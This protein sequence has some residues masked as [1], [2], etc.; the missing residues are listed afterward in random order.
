MALG[1]YEYCYLLWIKNKYEV[2]FSETAMLGRQWFYGVNEKINKISGSKRLTQ[3]DGYSETMFRSL[4]AND[5]RSYDISDYEGATDLVDFSQPISGEHQKRFSFVL[6]GG[7]LEHV[8]DFTTSVRNAMNMPKIGGTICLMTP[9]NSWNGHGFYQFS[10]ELFYRLFCEENGYELLDVSYRLCGDDA[11]EGLGTKLFHIPDSK[12][13]KCKTGLNSQFTGLLYVTARRIGELPDKFHIYESDYSEA[14][15]DR[16]IDIDLKYK[17]VA[18]PSYNKFYDL[19]MEME[20]LIS[21]IKTN[22]LRYFFS[23]YD[24]KIRAIVY[25]RGASYERE[26]DRLIENENIEIELIVDIKAKEIK[27]I[28]EDGF[29]Y[30]RPNCI[31]E[32]PFDI[33]IV[34]SEP[35]YYDIE[36]MLIYSYGLSFKQIMSLQEVLYYLS[37]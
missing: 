17:V 33:I 18:N 13:T 29:I 15:M 8:F 5:I 4:G 23:I 24:R 27:T 12:E 11:I 37:R 10:A 32:Y 7:L 20:N 22:W 35:H 6:D 14:W 1:N 31:K 21:P 16:N 3:D 9:S 26:K 25:G 36:N 34:T 19:E 30:A 2:S 28:D